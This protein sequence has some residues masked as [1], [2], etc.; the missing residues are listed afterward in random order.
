MPAQPRRTR[1]HTTRGTTD[2]AA[3]LVER[4]LAEIRAGGGR[5]TPARRAVLAAI[6]DTGGHHFTAAEIFAA[7][8]DA[9]PRPDR[10]TVYRTLDLLTELGVVTPLQLDGDATVYHRADHRHGHLVCTGCG[11]IAELPEAARQ[12]LARSVE[13]ETGFVVDTGRVAIAGWCRACAGKD[14]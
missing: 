3:S 9:R 13:D 7:V 5:V 11:T 14:L 8:D 12:L 6:L 4:T 2:V 1:T 10:A